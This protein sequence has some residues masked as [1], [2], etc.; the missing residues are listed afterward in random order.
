M[1]PRLG[2]SIERVW[3]IWERGRLGGQPP[4]A[5]RASRSVRRPARFGR[6]DHRL[7]SAQSPTLNAH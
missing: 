7:T 3:H 5:R 1:N 2:R 4:S 6:N